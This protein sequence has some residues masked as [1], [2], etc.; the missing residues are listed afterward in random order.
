MSRLYHLLTRVCWA[1][2]VLTLVTG[3][4]VK[5]TPKLKSFFDSMDTDPRGILI[6]AGVL[7]LCALA[8]HA[9]DRTETPGG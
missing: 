6:F 1:L 9:I 3:V 5:F 7:F 8:S 2:G 4:V